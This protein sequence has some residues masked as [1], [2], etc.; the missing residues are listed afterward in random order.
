MFLNLVCPGFELIWLHLG[1]YFERLPD[2]QQDTT[3][4]KW[5]L[6]FVPPFFHNDFMLSSNRERNH[7]KLQTRGETNK[8]KFCDM[9]GPQRAVDRYSETTV[10]LQKLRRA[11]PAVH[12]RAGDQDN[13]MIAKVSAET[14]NH[15]T[16]E[17]SA[18][19]DTGI[20]PLHQGKKRNMLPMPESYQ[21]T[22]PPVQGL[23]D[24]VQISV[25]RC[26]EAFAKRSKTANTAATPL[27]MR[28]VTCLAGWI[29]VCP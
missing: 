10:R 18:G 6:H 13:T 11:S 27:A 3:E 4:R 29:D 24:D 22:L 15:F 19:K 2:A 26:Q 28:D 25:F 5:K 17:R 21:Q 9:I 23:L 14:G 12:C 1:R 7:Q 8:A 20:K 16:P